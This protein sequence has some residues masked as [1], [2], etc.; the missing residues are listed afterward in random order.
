MSAQKSTGNGSWVES[1]VKHWWTS[2]SRM[3]GTRNL[4][5]FKFC[6]QCI[7]VGLRCFHYIDIYVCIT[8][9]QPRHW[10]RFCRSYSKRR[11]STFRKGPEGPRWMSSLGSTRRKQWRMIWSGPSHELNLYNTVT[12]QFCQIIT[13][14][15][16]LLINSRAPHFRSFLSKG[17]HRSSGC[18]LQPPNQG[19]AIGP[20]WFWIWGSCFFSSPRCWNVWMSLSF[21][22]ISFCQEG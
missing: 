16:M 14:Y 2:S 22:M 3:A 7:L 8:G 13:V 17:T 21:K 4:Q 18:L 11:S 9:P 6:V 5:R 20:D 1:P 15:N 12:F 19:E 10:N